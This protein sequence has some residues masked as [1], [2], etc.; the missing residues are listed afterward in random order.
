MP[1]TKPPSRK[2]TQHGGEDYW[3]GYS[4]GILAAIKNVFPFLA[5]NQEDKIH[6]YQPR[7]SDN[8]NAQHNRDLLW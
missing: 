1:E 5:Q 7:I 2:P 3:T 4:D 6:A 8:R